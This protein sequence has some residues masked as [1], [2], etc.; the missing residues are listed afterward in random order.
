MIVAVERISLVRL[1]GGLKRNRHQPGYYFKSVLMRK[2][3]FG[4]IKSI[5]MFGID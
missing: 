4:I 2:T 3:V 1:K 5:I